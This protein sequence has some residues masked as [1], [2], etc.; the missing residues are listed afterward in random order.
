[1][2]KFY[3]NN[4]SNETPQ[5]LSITRIAIKKKKKKKAIDNQWLEV[6]VKCRNPTLHSSAILDLG[7]VG[8]LLYRI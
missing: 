4:S 6:I 8:G 3:T 5:K 1:M 2:S 7:F